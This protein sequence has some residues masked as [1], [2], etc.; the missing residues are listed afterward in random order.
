M[1]RC[2]C[3][4]LLIALAGPVGAQPVPPSAHEA[5]AAEMVWDVMRLDSL[6]PVLRDE[7]LAEGAD[8]AAALFPQGAT[9]AWG[10]R[11]AA[12]HHPTRLRM[13]FLVGVARAVP[14]VDPAEAAAGLAFYRT[15]LGRRML[16]LEASARAAMLDPA[17]E[18]AAR[19]AYALA[20]RDSTPRARRIAGLIDAANLIEPNVAGGLN[21]SV[22]FAL[23]L[24]QGGGLPMPRP[25]AEIIRDAWAQ[26][27]QLR[28]EARD[29]IGAYLFLA[30]APLS[31]AE[32]DACIA[33][34]G[35]PGGRAVSRLMFAGFD[36]L[37]AQTSRDMG[38]AAA[39]E[40]RGQ[41]L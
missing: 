7:A 36:A 40:M 3:L 9:G 27:P 32:L 5:Q 18:A 6:A 1:L 37:F 8:M 16:T 11:V 34:A 4:S 14:G 15:P 28:A 10:A 20:Q 41:R 29:W 22:A 31:D 26:E 23:A 30:Y 35:T 19:D 2:M 25:E 39:A 13:L 12:I 33:Y 24:Q 21:A 38:L 17:T